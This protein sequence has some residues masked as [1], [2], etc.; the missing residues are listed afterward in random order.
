MIMGAVYLTYSAY[1]VSAHI[2]NVKSLITVVLNLIYLTLF[3]IV[4]KNT[5]K[6]LLILRM[7]NSVIR[8]SGIMALRDTIMLKIRML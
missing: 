3:Y 7:H 6:A 5:L 4:I 1:Y 2:E 8:H